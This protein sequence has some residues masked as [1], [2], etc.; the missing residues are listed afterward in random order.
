MNV[1]PDLPKYMKSCPIE[2]AI[3]H[4]GKKWSINIIRDLFNGKSRFSDFL[5]SSPK[6]STKMLAER[7]RELEKN[8]LIKKRVVNMTPLMITYELTDHGRALKPILVELGK[9][10]LQHC[11]KDVYRGGTE[12]LQADIEFMEKAFGN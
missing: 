2:T 9:F 4:I 7:L 8:G 3:E 12:T 5:R 11:Q 1:S 6:M 10:S